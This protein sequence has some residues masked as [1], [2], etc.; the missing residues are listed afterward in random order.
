MQSLKYTLA[1]LDKLYVNTYYYYITQFV[2]GKKVGQVVGQVVGQ[3]KATWPMDKL[4]A[5]CTIQ[6]ATG[7]TFNLT[8]WPSVDPWDVDKLRTTFRLSM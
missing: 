8:T 3:C 5:S 1:K 2:Q 4:M 6:T 7:K